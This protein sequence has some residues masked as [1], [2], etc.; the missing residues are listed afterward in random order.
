MFFTGYLGY[1]LFSGWQ[2]LADFVAFRGWRQTFPSYYFL[3]CIIAVTVAQM[4]AF[5]ATR[6]K[7]K[8]K[9]LPNPPP[10]NQLAP[11]SSDALSAQP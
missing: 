6:A 5:A 11:D 2:P 8:R 1:L 9:A 4:I 7:E 10:L 3:S